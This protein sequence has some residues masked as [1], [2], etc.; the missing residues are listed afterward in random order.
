MSRGNVEWITKNVKNDGNCGH[1]SVQGIDRHTHGYGH[2][3]SNGHERV[4]RAT[5]NV[6]SKT[7][8]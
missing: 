8:L 2:S 4:N 6:F 3:H 5:Y 1:D 7:R